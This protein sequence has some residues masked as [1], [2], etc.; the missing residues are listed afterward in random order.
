MFRYMIA[1]LI[2][3]CLT[4]TSMEAAK[5]PKEEIKNWLFLN[6]TSL[7][8]SWSSIGDTGYISVDLGYSLTIA[9]Y[10]PTGGVRRTFGLDIEVPLYVSAL[11]SSN[12]ITSGDKISESLGW[13]VVLPLT[14]GIEA[15]NFWLKGL[16]GYTYNEISEGFDVASNKQSIVKINM[17][18]HGFTYGVQ[19]GWRYKNILN[20]GLKAMFGKLQ[21]TARNANGSGLE[22]AIQSKDRQYNLMRFG[23]FASIT[24]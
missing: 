18:Y 13:G 20:L 12:G 1:S 21:N 4:I 11:G 24:F 15:K 9:T 23:G 14:I 17:R 16:F 6:D 2:C 3:V 19:L 8:A 5:K 7:G 10:A 22:T